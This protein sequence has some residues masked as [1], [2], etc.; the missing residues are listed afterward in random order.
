MLT[1][2]F[3]R[4]KLPNI[5]WIETLYGWLERSDLADAGWLDTLEDRAQG[6]TVQLQ[7]AAEAI[8]RYT[9]DY[10]HA[11]P[12]NRL[13]LAGLGALLREVQGEIASA[14]NGGGLNRLQNS[15]DLLL[16]AARR[17]AR[18]EPDAPP[19]G[20]AVVLLH[21]LGRSKLSMMWLDQNLTHAG[22]T[23]HNIDYPSTQ[24]PIEYLA[25]NL[26]APL[27]PAIA[28]SAEKIHFVTHS[29]GGI[30][31]RYI[32]HHHPPALSGRVV[33][34]SPPNQGSEMVDLLAN[35]PLFHAVC[36]PAGLQLGTGESAL[37]H[38]IG[39]AG[40]REIGIIVGN[41]SVDPVS[42]RLIPGD[43]DGKVS[44][45]R[46]QLEGMTDFLVLPHSHT[47]IMHSATVI[48]QTLHFLK[49]GRFDHAAARTRYGDL[50]P[51]Q[52]ATPQPDP[53][54]RLAADSKN[55]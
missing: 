44:V 1:D 4:L 39:P 21:G 36:G 55:A 11:T 51:Q 34:L 53:A 9:A 8:L 45:T 37:P 15:V 22:Y 35:N 14:E 40:G 28:E 47:F 19:N 2:L 38:C 7:E 32:L 12:Q 46:A 50:F 13:T 17:Q 6:A 3:A 16:D 25:S 29:M 49:F 42:S 41:R 33:M 48:G 10:G 23:V 30:I 26:I 54:L 27:L 43:N 20:E 52:T 18:P 31:T 5:D 24:Y